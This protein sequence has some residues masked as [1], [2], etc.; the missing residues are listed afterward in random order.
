MSSKHGKKSWMSHIH[1][2]S[3]RLWQATSL[4]IYSLKRADVC[5]PL[6][7]IHHLLTPTADTPPAPGRLL[8]H[9]RE[10]WVPHLFACILRPWDR[11]WSFAHFSH[12][13]VKF[14]KLSYFYWSYVTWP[15]ISTP[16]SLAPHFPVCQAA[17]CE[18]AAD[19]PLWK[20]RVHWVG[21]RDVSCVLQSLWCRDG[22][23]LAAQ[24]RRGFQGFSPPAV[25]PG[26][27]RGSPPGHLDKQVKGQNQI[28]M[29]YC[30]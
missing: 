13:L 18:C 27:A 28:W 26:T 3:S 11:S 29:P 19:P 12:F 24:L 7:V 25:G 6:H 20:L 5:P 23:L 1:F 2:H 10:G 16:A 17:C 4:H 9:R 22:L 15:F 30:D 21:I 14:A 8:S